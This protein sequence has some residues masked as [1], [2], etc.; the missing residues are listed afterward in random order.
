VKR[1]PVA[2]SQEPI[3][4]Q[5]AREREKKW[6]SRDSGLNNFGTEGIEKRE[7]QW[8]VNGEQWTEEEHTG[9]RIAV[10]ERFRFG[11]RS[12]NKYAPEEGNN[13][14]TLRGRT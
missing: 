14:Q 2:N 10:S 6:K 3:K 9:E 4:K 12:W 5:G 7:K 11:L 13:R 1:Q 8:S